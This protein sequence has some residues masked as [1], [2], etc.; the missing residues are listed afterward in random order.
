M[1]LGPRAGGWR[2]RSTCPGEWSIGR[3]PVRQASGQYPR[4]LQYHQRQRGQAPRSEVVEDDPPCARKPLQLASRP[5][6]DDV[7][8]AERDEADD[9]RCP[10]EPDDGDHRDEKSG[11]FVDHDD[12]RIGL[13]LLVDYYG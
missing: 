4:R 12:L 3:T 8:Q 2:A 6:L 13:A 11:H 7:E 1:L 9:Q 5:W 10:G